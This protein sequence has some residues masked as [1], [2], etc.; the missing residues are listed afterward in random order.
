[1]PRHVQV[2][3]NRVSTPDTYGIR[4]RYFLIGGGGTAILGGGGNIVS[5]NEV[6]GADK[7][8]IL[9][10]GY[11]DTYKIIGDTIAHNQ[12]DRT[13]TSG[14]ATLNT[15]AGTFDNAAIALGICNGDIVVNNRIDDSQTVPTMP[16]GISL[17][18]TAAST[19]VKNGTLIANN[20]S[21]NHT[22]AAIRIKNASK[23][24]ADTIIRGNGGYNPKGA[25]TAPAV[26]ATAVAQS[27]TFNVDCTVFV[28][29]GAGSTTEV[30]IGGTSAVTI[31][32]SDTGTVRVPVS[33]TIT[34]TYTSAPTWTWFGD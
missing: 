24:N 5:G 27:N 11:N 30:A 12:I 13:N 4:L 17:G 3:N 19:N 20:V 29:A 25:V 21:R 22:A 28:T 32:A 34:L 6:R 18:G 10:D 8:G 1:M 26:P 16:Y 15:G 14:T 31:A 2:V 9:V 7:I 33:Q 23:V